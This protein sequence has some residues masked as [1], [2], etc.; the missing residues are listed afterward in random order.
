MLQNNYNLEVIK[1]QLQQNKDIKS[2]TLMAICQR[3][4][5]GNLCKG[6]RRKRDFD[7]IRDTNRLISFYKK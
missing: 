5:N 4:Y 2:R 6:L 1:L 3:L 7:Q